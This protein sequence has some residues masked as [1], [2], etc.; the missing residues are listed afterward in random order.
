MNKR[1]HQSHHIFAFLGALLLIFIIFFGIQAFEKTYNFEDISVD[2]AQGYYD[3]ANTTNPF[4][5]HPDDAL[6]QV[7][8]YH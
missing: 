6:A 8:D 7:A 2:D 5:P 4:F 3:G 1:H